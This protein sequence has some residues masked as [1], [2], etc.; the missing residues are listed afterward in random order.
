MH[1]SEIGGAGLPSG[2]VTF[3]LTDVEGSTRLW[4]SD[5]ASAVGALARHREILDG[6]I[7][8][9]RGARPVEQGEGD[10]TV[11]AFARPSDALQAARE[12]QKLLGEELWPTEA[13]LRVRMALHTGE[14]QV[15]ADGTYMGVALNR[16]ARLRALAHGGQVL[17]SSATRDL[18]IDHLGSDLQLSDLGVHRLR[19]LSRPERVWQL[20][21][22]GLVDE[23]PAL[24]SLDFV[25]N[26]LPVQLSSFVG[27]DDDIARVVTL[28][29]ETRLLTLTGAGG[30]GK[31]RLAQRIAAEVIDQY[32]GGAWWAE[33]A[34]VTNG[35][36]IIETFATV[37]GEKVQTD[38]AEVDVLAA[39]LGP[40][41]VLLVLDNCEHL[42]AEAAAFTDRL[43][44][45]NS[46]V[47]IVATSR[48][49]LGVEGE[50]TWRVPS[51]GLPP[52]E[53]A[54]PGTVEQSDAVR[55]FIERA[56][57]VRPNF[58]VTNDNAA[59]VAQICHRLD[60]IPLAI[61][62][63]AARTRVLPPER[64]AAELDHRFRLLTGHSR[65][66]VPRQ[67]TLL[68]SVDWSH[69]LLEPLE[70]VL[71]RRLGVF[72]G[73]FSLDAAEAV[74]SFEPLCDYDILDLISRLVDKS[75]VQMDDSA[76]G[77]GRY[78]LL[79]TIR[80][81]ALDRLQDSGEVTEIH[82][83]HL[84][85]ACQL[86][87][88]LESGSTNARPD[89]LDQLDTEYPNIRAALEWATEHGELGR[90]RRMV[91]ALGLFWAQRGHY[92]EASTWESRLIG[93]APSSDP[94]VA[95][96]RW[97]CAYVRFYAG[98]FLGSYEQAS[99]AL[100]EARAAGDNAT[101]ARCLHTVSSAMLGVDPGAAR[102]GLLEAVGL[103]RHGE[104][105]WCVADALQIVAYTHLIETDHALARPILEE[106]YSICDRLNNPFQRAWHHCGLA[107]AA[108]LES[109]FDV[110]EPEI[111]DAISLAR[112]V[113][114]PGLQVRIC[115]ILVQI[116][117]EQGRLVDIGDEVKKMHAERREWGTLG[118]GLLAGFSAI[119][120][121]LDD[122]SGARIQLEALGS[123]FLD[124]GDTLDGP[125]LLLEG[126]RAAL[127]ADCFE[128]AG[129][130]ASIV[131]TNSPG[132][133]AD[134]GR[135]LRGVAARAMDD[136]SAAD[137]V[138]DS[139]AEFVR[140][141]VMLG[142]PLAV[143]TLGGLAIN[144]GTPLE[145]TR[146]LAAADLLREHTGQ[147]RT[148]A[149]QSRFDRDVAAARQSIPE[150][151]E[152]TWA[153]GSRLSATDAAAYARRARGE[154][155]RPL[156]GWNSLTPT[157]RQ[158][159]ELAA[160]G[161]TNPQ[162][163]EQL[164]MGRGTVKTHLAHIYSKLDIRSRAELASAAARQAVGTTTT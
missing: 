98:D 134:N 156:S 132:G 146:L 76:Q 115:L 26:N 77:S 71:M 93:P 129:R 22:P 155:R 53:G 31:T 96:A 144:G 43:L 8:R 30:C 109:R 68:A 85:W 158:V 105:E 126:A 18:A 161:L 66:G 69:D 39:L 95:R 58:R 125:Y 14:V 33:L 52:P 135:L 38:R 107:W 56:L 102:Q 83:R 94:L 42:V 111:G 104:D 151:F 87:A 113:G 131:E 6:V 110:A 162:I 90:A 89:V 37:L 73:G 2:A 74:C 154:R 88:E 116:L 57:Q 130:L 25:P 147:R 112:L 29:G 138:H 67:Q 20:S 92:A 148:P 21:G 17:V 3:L 9:W 50:V 59:A 152:S 64:I 80:H 54:V 5:P 36:L 28:L 47:A 61:E 124:A 159:V 78:Q 86:V 117:R 164:F 27:R 122:P 97:A 11:S 121:V 91:G 123:S 34:S 108:M 120:A 4:E 7:A 150:Q 48:E 139:L 62:L 140:H 163:G 55:L 15:R 44:R 81:Y 70:Q 157:E 136:P 12:A 1:A 100:E 141:D 127:E 143:E 106:A 118:A 128:D 84:G 160:K 149:E 119:S 65:M 137:L 35:A 49:P 41:P 72:A 45:A 99:I 133:W 101:A 24:Q 79:E 114:D 10:S 23:H 32:P 142:V 153:E 82:D 13:H 16:C 103:A 51:L 145:G 63:A 75:L 60:G 40:A 19:D 46:A